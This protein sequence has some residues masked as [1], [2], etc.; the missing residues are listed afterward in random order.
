MTWNHKKSIFKESSQNYVNDD[1]NLESAILLST[2]HNERGLGKIA[3][4]KYVFPR[5][6]SI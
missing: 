3:Y 5:D 2:K 4:N 1:T 6:K